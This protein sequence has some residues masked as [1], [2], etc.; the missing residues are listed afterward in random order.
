VQE[1]EA[2]GATKTITIDPP[3]RVK[4]PADEV[5]PPVSKRSVVPAVVLGV[6]A[7]GAIGT[8]IGAT[9]A[10]SSNNSAAY[11]AGAVL[12]SE[13]GGCVS[14]W[15]SYDPKQCANIQNKLDAAQTYGNVAV[16]TFIVG[17]A[18][19]AGMVLYLVWP[20]PQAKTPGQ[21]SAPRVRLTPI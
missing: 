7:A 12:N 6:L 16:G 4:V 21:V 5:K 14:H 1:I 15:A 20:S 8:G 19:A 9:V 10:W 17:G 3:V 2:D 11:K 18:A 13:F